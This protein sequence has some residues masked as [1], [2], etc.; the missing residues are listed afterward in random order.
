MRSLLLSSLL[1]LLFSCAPKIHQD[2][3]EISSEATLTPVFDASK[4][5]LYKAKIDILKYY[6]SGLLFIKPVTEDTFRLVFTNELGIKFFDIEF[7][8]KGKTVHYIMEKMNKKAVINTLEKDMKLFL[9]ND[10]VMAK[11]QELQSETGSTVFKFKGDKENYFYFLND[12]S[13]LERIELTTKKKVKVE[14]DLKDYQENVPHLINIKH[15]NFKFNI[16]L[17]YLQR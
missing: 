17:N 4:S 15:H 11:A 1:I 5:Y 8:P 3:K 7:F 13:V 10:L 9:M 6:L 16:E 2:Y 14:V 12:S